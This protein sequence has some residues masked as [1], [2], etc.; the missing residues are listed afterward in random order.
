MDMDLTTIEQPRKK[1]NSSAT[2]APASAAIIVPSPD[3]VLWTSTHPQ[4]QADG[5]RYM[6]NRLGLSNAWLDEAGGFGDEQVSKYLGP[7]RAKQIGPWYYMML[8]SLLAV[9]W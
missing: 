2:T 9:K 7:S 6:Q 4:D 1:R 3:E 8:N 5:F